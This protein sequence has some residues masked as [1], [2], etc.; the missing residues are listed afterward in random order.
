MGRIVGHLERQTLEM[1]TLEITLFTSERN[2]LQLASNQTKICLVETSGGKIVLQDYEIDAIQKEYQFDPTCLCALPVLTEIAQIG[3]KTAIDLLHIYAANE[4]I[5][6]ALYT[7][8]DD[9]PQKSIREKLLQ[10]KEAVLQNKE[11]WRI[12]KTGV[13][14][15]SLEKVIF[16]AE[17]MFSAESNILLKN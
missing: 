5:I 11:S 15:F 13:I 8:L 12:S 14:D 7:N 10:N 9:V 1:E 6:A 16:Q 3:R 2:T 4:D 17:N